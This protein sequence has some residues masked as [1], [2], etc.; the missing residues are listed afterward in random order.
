M[1]PPPPPEG[2]V[3]RAKIGTK[4]IFFRRKKV[5]FEKAHTPS[6]FVVAVGGTRRISRTHISNVR[7]LF[8]VSARAALAAVLTGHN[9]LDFRWRLPGRTPG[10]LFFHRCPVTETPLI[11][12]ADALDIFRGELT[13]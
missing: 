8:L 7:G 6:N 4:F 13:D 10:S 11:F 3:I 9:Y 2:G 5:V 1:P 12:I